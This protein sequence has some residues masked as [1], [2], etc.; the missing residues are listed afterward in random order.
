MTESSICAARAQW[1][2]ISHAN[3]RT[4]TR[5]CAACFYGEC[6]KDHSQDDCDCHK[7]NPAIPDLI[8]AAD[9]ARQ[10][11]ANLT[12]AWND[13]HEAL[14]EAEKQAQEICICAA[15][16]DP[17]TGEIVRG[18]RHAGPMAQIW[19]RHDPT[20]KILDEHQGFITSR[21]R[22]V[23]REEGLRLQKAAGI[24]SACEGRG[25][26]EMQLTSE[27]LYDGEY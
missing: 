5:G 8:A 26:L 22:F 13:E 3:N 1:D 20:P 7:S 9:T 4:L 2:A 18:H 19:Q 25:Y 23:G 21:N 27:D 17:I 16:I 6:N 10:Q 24:E 14:L 15:V 12:A 11:L